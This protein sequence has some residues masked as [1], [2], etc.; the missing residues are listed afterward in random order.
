MTLRN[1]HHPIFPGS[2]IEA[3]GEIAIA[4]AL[5]NTSLI[6]ESENSQKTKKSIIIFL[7]LCK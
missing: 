1:H 3:D 4:G 2:E 5:K 7:H 6:L